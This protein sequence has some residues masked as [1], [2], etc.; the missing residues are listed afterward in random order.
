MGSGREMGL[1]LNQLAMVFKAEKKTIRGCMDAL[2]LTNS[3]AAFSTFKKVEATLTEIM[4]FWEALDTLG[5][6]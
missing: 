6:Y 2:V 3:K 4:R 5:S 1:P